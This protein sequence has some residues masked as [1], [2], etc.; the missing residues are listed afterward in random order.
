MHEKYHVSSVYN[1]ADILWLQ[2]MLHVMLI[3]G[4]RSK[5]DEN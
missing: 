1:I 5:E 3:L 4:F 2:I